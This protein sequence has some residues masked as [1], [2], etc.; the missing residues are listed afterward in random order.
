MYDEPLRRRRRSMTS[1]ILEVL[2]RHR[3]AL[4]P[5][6]AAGWLQARPALGWGMRPPPVA[7]PAPAAADAPSPAPAPER[8][9]IGEV[10]IVTQG[11]FNPDRQGEDKLAF[12][13]ADRLHRTT[14]PQVIR[15]QL[16]FAPGDPY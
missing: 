13:L 7:P 4:L 6:L 8:P 16:L 15:R 12:R 11:I 10:R 3:L 1:P 14:R 5:L 2:R 9:V